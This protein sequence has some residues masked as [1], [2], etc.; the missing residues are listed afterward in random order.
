MSLRRGAARGLQINVVL[1][2]PFRTIEADGYFL[3]AFT[4]DFM[5]VYKTSKME[6]GKQ[7]CAERA[8][9]PADTHFKLSVLNRVFQMLPCP[10]GRLK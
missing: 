9:T 2:T 6:S 1:H 4:D 5:N 8:P 7:S 10:W 3:L